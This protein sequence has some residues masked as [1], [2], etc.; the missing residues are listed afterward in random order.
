MSILQEG[1][2]EFWFCGID[3]FWNR[4]YGFAS[5]ICDFLFFFCLVVYGLSRFPHSDISFESKLRKALIYLK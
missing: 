5:K 2:R 1:H 4:F 3:R